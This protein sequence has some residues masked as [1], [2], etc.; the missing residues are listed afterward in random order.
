MSK[1]PPTPPRRSTPR[2]PSSTRRSAGVSKLVV[3]AGPAEGKEFELKLEEHVIGR[4]PDNEVSL[5][6]KSMSRRHAAVVKHDEGW[7]IRDLGSGAGTLLNGEAVNEELLSNDDVITLGDTELRY[8]APSRALARAGSQGGSL[9]GVRRPVRTSRQTG[10]GSGGGK[11]LLVAF[12]VL[13]VIAVGAAV[14][15]R[16]WSTSQTRVTQAQNAVKAEQQAALARRFQDART[17]VKEG[18]FEEAKKV[19]EGIEAEDEAFEPDSVRVYLKRTE[20]EIPIERLLNDV[21]AALVAKKV[22]PAVDALA[23][24]KKTMQTER[25]ASLEMELDALVDAQVVQAKALMAKTGDRQAMAEMR[26]LVDEALVRRPEDRELAQ[27]KG[28]ADQ[29]IA[30]IDNPTVVPERIEAPQTAVKAR[31]R[32]GDVTGALLLAKQCAAKSPECRRLEES[33]ADVQQRLSKVDGLSL[34]EMRALEVLDRQLSG[35]EPT[36]Q[37]R[38]LRARLAVQL[39]QEAS[40]LKLSQEWV[41]AIARARDVLEVEPGHPGAKQLLA[42]GREQ[43]RE[44]YLR[45]YTLKGSDPDE[46]QK[47][48][49]EVLLMSPPDDESHQKAKKIIDDLQRQ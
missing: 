13:A 46:A 10:G 11:S 38:P 36:P 48:C 4:A 6:D 12:V 43:A 27:L 20:E 1:A 49:R 32:Q 47:H 16:V 18:K 44:L 30:R 22:R 19:L 23:R 8:Q 31:Y 9:S 17:F 42:D 33:L 15:W 5:A 34:R 29:A 39:F 24:V 37:A 14:G 41:K 25:K 2:S 7:L 3:I 35:G 45:C 40:K 21:K 28:V 26:E